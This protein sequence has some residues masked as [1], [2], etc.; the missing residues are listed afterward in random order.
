MAEAQS[1]GSQQMCERSLALPNRGSQIQNRDIQHFAGPY[2]QSGVFHEMN[3]AE[4]RIAD[5]DG[6][7][8]TVRVPFFLPSSR[9]SMIRLMPL[10]FLL[11][12]D[13]GQETPKGLEPLQG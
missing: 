12:A 9:C 3:G 4:K 13:P 2:L 7:A 1:E 5:A 10:A 8:D 11:L 6:S